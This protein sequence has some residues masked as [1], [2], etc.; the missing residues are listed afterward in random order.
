MRADG[1]R[2][3]RREFLP[4]NPPPRTL[5]GALSRPVR[6]SPRRPGAGARRCIICASLR[7]GGLPRPPLGCLQDIGRHRR[8]FWHG[9]R[10]GRTV[11]PAQG[12]EKQPRRRAAQGRCGGARAV[13]PPR[14]AGGHCRPRCRQATCPWCH[15][16]TC[17]FALS[18][19]PAGNQAGGAENRRQLCGVGR[20]LLHL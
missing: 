3:R 12:P 17:F 10:G 19:T 15:P 11:A 5:A 8:R 20:P 14:P 7:I 2:T 16:P 1:R 6:S 18:V 9:S 13:E 4:L